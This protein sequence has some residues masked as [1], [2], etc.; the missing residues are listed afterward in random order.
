MTSEF[1]ENRKRGVHCNYV[2]TLNRLTNTN[3]VLLK[4]LQKLKTRLRRRKKKKNGICHI[5]QRCNLTNQKKIV[6]L[7]FD[8]F[9]KY[10]GNSAPAC[11]RVASGGERLKT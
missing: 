4:K 6:S 2:V 5:F 9:L 7:L 8:E 10:N 3:R 11:I 1:L